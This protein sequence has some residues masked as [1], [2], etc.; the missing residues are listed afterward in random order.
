MLVR[1][2]LVVRLTVAP[3]FIDELITVS[4]SAGTR[5]N[6]Y[7]CTQAVVI[8]FVMLFMMLLLSVMTM[9]ECESLRLVINLKTVMQALVCPRVLLV[10]KA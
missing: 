8:K 3:L 1:P 7:L 2:P 5:I 6:P 10:L 4:R 9:L